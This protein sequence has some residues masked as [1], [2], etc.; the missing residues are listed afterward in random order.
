MQGPLHP[1]WVDTAAGV[2]EVA[3]RCRA[4]GRFALDT[5]ADSLH[6]YFHKTCLVQVTAA[7]EHFLVDPLALERGGLEPLWKVAGDPAL[8]VL[9]HGADYDVRVLDRDYGV[10]IHGLEDTQIM[11]LL[12]GEPKTG[13]A[14]LLERDLGVGL[15]KRFQRADWGAR[16]VGRALREYAAADTAWLEQLAAILRSRLEALGRWRWAVEEF[17]ALEEVRHVP[18]EPD[19]YGFE[20]VKGVRSLRG[21]ARDRAFTLYEWREERAR[22]A[23][24]PPFRILGNRPLVALAERPPDDLDGVAAVDGLGPRFARRLGSAVLEKLSRPRSAPPFRKGHR[25]PAPPAA[26]RLRLDRVAAVRDRR[27]RELELPTGL[28]CPKA[29]LS[30]VAFADPVPADRRGLE[31]AGLT[32]WRLEQLGD[33]VLA[34]LGEEG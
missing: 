21:A 32:G 13:L 16:P 23:D 22:Q 27:A 7:R 26:L 11:A 33:E 12:L 17:R 15:D 5:E 10:R 24:V 31:E 25:E 14:A 2:A 6:S 30:E 3:S 9:M 8:R 4:A 18:P 34:A 19:P 29:T 20:R 28:L 1:R